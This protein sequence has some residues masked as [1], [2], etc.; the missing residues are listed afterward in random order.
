MEWPGRGRVHQAEVNMSR[1]ACMIVAALAVA[2]PAL[3]VPLTTTAPA[4][5]TP[6]TT[7]THTVLQKRAVFD[8]VAKATDLDRVCDGQRPRAVEVRRT[9]ADVAA[10]VFSGLWYTPVH[11]RVT[12]GPES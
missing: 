6:A 1:K 8:L 12:C 7:T 4:N 10:A 3:A 9:A 2:T 5:T 11:L